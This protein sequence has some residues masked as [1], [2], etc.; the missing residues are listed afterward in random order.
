MGNSVKPKKALSQHFLRDRRVLERIVGYADLKKGDVVLEIGA[1]NGVLTR[2]LCD[3]GA[4]V[5]AVEKDQA[6]VKAYLLHLEKE[7]ENLQVI[8]GDAL[9]IEMPEFTKIVSNLPYRISSDIT[10]RI[11]EHK[12][13]RG[14]LMYQREFAERLCA[15]HGSPSYGRLSVNAYYRAKCEILEIVPRGAFFPV[16]KVESAVVQ[17]IPRKR[18]PFKV[19][20]I[21]IFTELVNSAF[22]HRRKKMGTILGRHWARCDEPTLE[23]L[24]RKNYY[25]KR[26]EELSPEDFGEIANWVWERRREIRQAH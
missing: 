5:I 2:A 8:G 21:K 12:F 18:P 3:T 19:A 10:F 14:V 25:D 17:V 15:S 6:L 7:Y 4:E 16:P 11:L 22:Q 20:S 26:P 13:E 24:R 23:F 1:G 9:E